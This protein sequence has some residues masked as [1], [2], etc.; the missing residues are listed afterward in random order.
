MT[1]QEPADLNRERA[2]RCLAVLFSYTDFDPMTNLIDLL[3]DA[4]HW[5]RFN[6]RDFEWAL[7][8]ARDHFRMEIIESGGGQP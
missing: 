6:D 2:A 5:C 4:M 8:K 7:S 3:A 1:A